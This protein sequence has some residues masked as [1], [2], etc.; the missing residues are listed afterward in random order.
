MLHT[1]TAELQKKGTHALWRATY[2]A[3]F[4]LPSC[5]LSEAQMPP[6]TYM[7]GLHQP[8]THLHGT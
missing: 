6:G 2:L 5:A 1:E 8:C 4:A 3:A 7:I